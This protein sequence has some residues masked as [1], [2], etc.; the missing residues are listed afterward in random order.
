[1]DNGNNAVRGWASHG[2][3]LRRMTQSSPRAREREKI[4]SYNTTVSTG[5]YDT[6]LYSLYFI[7][8]PPII[9]LLL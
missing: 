6:M 9:I 1:M 5:K 4:I 8:V 3:F 2:E 7:K